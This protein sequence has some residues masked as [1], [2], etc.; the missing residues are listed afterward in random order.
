M[1]TAA[2]LDA[3]LMA[4]GEPSLE[5][6]AAT[7][8]IAVEADAAWKKVSTQRLELAEQ[9]ADSAAFHEEVSSEL[10]EQYRS[11]HSAQVAA[12]TRRTLAAEELERT[13]EA[14]SGNART[15]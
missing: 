9:I 15:E 6:I 7:R 8:E 11:L 10:L 14:H 4:L 2:A 13:L 3:A 5:H 1:T 12:R